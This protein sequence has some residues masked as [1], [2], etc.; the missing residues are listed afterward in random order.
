MEVLLT[1]TDNSVYTL[2][3]KTPT[4]DKIV[5]LYK[6]SINFNKEDDYLN[7]CLNNLQ[8]INYILKFANFESII[9]LFVDKK[10]LCNYLSKELIQ[11]VI[12]Y[13]QNEFNLQKEKKYILLNN[14]FN[15]FC[16]FNIEIYK[17]RLDALLPECLKDKKLFFGETMIYDICNNTSYKEIANNTKEYFWEIFAQETFNVLAYKDPNLAKNKFYVIKHNNINFILQTK[18][19]NNI[20]NNNLFCGDNNNIYSSPL[21]YHTLANQTYIRKEINTDIQNHAEHKMLLIGNTKEKNTIIFDKNI[22]HNCYI[23]KKIYNKKHIF[24]N[25]TFMC[26]ECGMKNYEIEKDI[27]NMQNMTAFIT[28][29]RHTIGFAIALKLLRAG[30]LVIGTSRFP[31]CAL[32]NY[33]QEKDYDIWKDKLI[34]CQCDF[35]NMESVQKT[36]ELVKSYKPH[37]VINNACQTVRPTKEYYQRVSAIENN[38]ADIMYQI[39]DKNMQVCEDNQIVNVVNSLYINKKWCCVENFPKVQT[40]I[41]IPVNFTR[42]IC[43][44]SLDPKHNSW[45]LS[46]QEVSMTE[47]LEVNAINQITPTIIIQQILDHM[48][49]PSFVIQVSAKEGIFN[50][51]KSTEKGLHAHTNM[52]KAGMNMLIRT[53]SETKRQNCNFYAVDPGYVSGTVDKEYPLSINDGA[54]RVIYPIISHIKGKTLEQGHYKNYKLHNW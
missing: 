45:T 34:I 13:H 41:S 29:I 11:E 53:L 40:N 51:N 44:P 6:R 2:E 5:E 21:G 32:H 24:P 22:H 8:Y 30:C 35:L 47:L 26:F 50:A 7:F 4:Q 16:N 17:K 14:K 3:L 52:C 20:F 1:L 39:K 54:Q 27:V 25:Y 48:Q 28:G 33:Q 12:N 10:L 38:I 15:S 49:S 42:N 46:L 18:N 36:I 43:D 9:K 31:M 23:C 37:I 19:T